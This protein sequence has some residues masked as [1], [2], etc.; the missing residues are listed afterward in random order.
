MRKEDIFI[1]VYTSFISIGL[2]CFIAYH[3]R[4]IIK[5]RRETEEEKEI[6]EAKELEKDKKNQEANQRINFIFGGIIS[7]T[8]FLFILCAAA[9]ILYQVYHWLKI[10]QWIEM[11]FY[12]ILSKV[13]ISIGNESQFEWKGIA[14]I[15]IWISNQS[16][17]LVMAI[18]GFIITIIGRNTMD[19]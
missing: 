18:L 3:I 8:G 16:S 7:L 11:P 9:I 14:K 4:K 15:F 10:G 1:W 2:F 17:A 12:N 6:R 13:D 5:K 19:A